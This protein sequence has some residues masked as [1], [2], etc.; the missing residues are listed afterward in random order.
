MKITRTKTEVFEVNVEKERERLKSCFKG[1]QL[2][3]QEAILDAMFIEQNL[4]KV[5]EL[6]HALPYC[7]KGGCAEQEY[8]GLWLCVFT[9]G[10]CEYDN[11]LIKTDVTY[12]LE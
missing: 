4:E 9:G 1:K 5:R 6:Y 2:K 12:K 3:R 8:T 10:F 11:R 7:S